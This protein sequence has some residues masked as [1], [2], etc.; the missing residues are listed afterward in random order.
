MELY[1]IH[2]IGASK[3]LYLFKTNTNCRYSRCTYLIFWIIL[4]KYLV[5]Q[6]STLSLIK[7]F[8]M[9]F[10][11]KIIAVFL[12]T[13]IITKHNMSDNVSHESFFY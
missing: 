10:H 1:F 7:N 2:D 3:Y 8:I 4:R 13:Q 6:Y 11:L 5:L 9:K 12:F